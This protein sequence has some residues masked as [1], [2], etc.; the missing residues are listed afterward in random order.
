M[1]KDR[2]FR[3]NMKTETVSLVGNPDVTEPVSKTFRKMLKTFLHFP[4]IVSR[5]KEMIQRRKRV[6][7]TDIFF[8]ETKFGLFFFDDIDQVAF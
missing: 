6:I 7:K 2:T 5:I 8:K 3:W 1:N 4:C